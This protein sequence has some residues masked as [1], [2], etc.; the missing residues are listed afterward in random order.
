[1]SMNNNQKIIAGITVLIIVAISIWYFASPKEQIGTLETTKV[2]IGGLPITQGLPLFLA[3][4]KGYFKEAGLDVEWVKFE[5]PNQIVD[6]LLAGQIDLSHTGGPMS[7]V[8]IA[9][10]KNPGKLK[11]FAAAGGDEIIANDSLMVK[12]DSNIN[13]ILE[14]EGK[15]L[16]ILAGIQWRTIAQHILA[17]NNLVADDDVALVE[18]APSLQAQALA[19]G[20]IDAL[21]AIEPVP[22]IVKNQNIGREIVHTPTA[23]YV[24]NPFYGGAGIIRADFVTQ[25]PR[26]TKLVL[27]VFTRAVDEM[28]A[29][30][31]AARQYQRGYTP[32]ED[33]LISQVPIPKIKMYH[34]FSQDDVNAI[35]TFL[36]IFT[37]YEVVNGKINFQQ[38]LYSPS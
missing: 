6:A 33:N 18:L 13:S 9:D 35:Q 8:A 12:K 27:D 38:I 10:F 32:L 1:M 25:N 3:L 21:L 11:I 31:D 30:L 15:R 24:S 5:A 7:I 36:D 28:N 4:E 22:T 14:L 37:V 34:G 16:G 17:Q 2:K 26:A 29:D 19:S 23:L 20:Q